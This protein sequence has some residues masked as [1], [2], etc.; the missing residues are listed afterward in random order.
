MGG[1]D[2][3]WNEFAA[4]NDAGGQAAAGIAVDLQGGVAVQFDLRGVV[5]ADATALA[6][7]AT[8]ERAEITHE[9]EPRPRGEH[10]HG[11]LRTLDIGRRRE[12]E[13]AAVASSVGHDH[14]Q[15]VAG[16]S[17][18]PVMMW[19][20]FAQRPKM[21]RSLMNTAPFKA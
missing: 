19:A 14:P 18:V 5:H 15:S 4:G 11:E 6:D 12:H 13:P 16:C 20:P 10:G 17:V 8:G 7:A 1:L 21:P 3:E 2:E 9:V